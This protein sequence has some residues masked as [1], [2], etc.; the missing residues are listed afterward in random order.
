MLQGCT[1]GVIIMLLR[2]Q[3]K[4]REIG[5][6]TPLTLL[7]PLANSPIYILSLP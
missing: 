1:S 6:K 3:G 2:H 5:E 4:P 7:T